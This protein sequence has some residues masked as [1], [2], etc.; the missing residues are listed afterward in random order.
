MTPEFASLVNPI[1]HYV[2]DLASRIKAGEAVS[3]QAAQD[4]IHKRIRGAEENAPRVIGESAAKDFELARRGMVYWIDEVM[5]VA[6]PAWQ[7]IKL[8]WRYFGTQ[9]RGWKFYEE[10]ELQARKSTGDVIELWY[11]SLVLGFQGDIEWGCRNWHRRDI[12]PPTDATSAQA[13]A[14]VQETRQRWAKELERLIPE[15]RNLVDRQAPPLY[16][17]V[18]P[19]MWTQISWVVF[20]WLIIA[21]LL[22]AVLLLAWQSAET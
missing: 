12:V 7:E 17:D 10:G 14:W 21:S 11:L 15:R 22:W 18:T 6:D 19:L 8:E 20:I 1:I 4:E 2:L 3:L 16:G 13:E 9:D 5:T